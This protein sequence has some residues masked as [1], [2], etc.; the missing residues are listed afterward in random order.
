MTREVVTLALFPLRTVL[1]PGGLL[2]LRIFETRYVDMVRNCMREQVP[3]GVV[4]LLEGAEAGGLSCFATLGTS[5]RIAD[6][7]PLP[8]GLLGISC[9]GERKFRVLRHW[10][11]ADLLNMGEVEW[12][13]DEPSE[14]LPQRHALLRGLLEQAMAKVGQH[15][16]N[17]EQQLDDA[18]WIGYRLSE[19][20]SLPVEERQRSLELADPIERIDWLAPMLDTA[21]DPS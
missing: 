3:F 7:D 16:D 6:F 13:G 17:W 15:Y 11:A 12:L 19:L 4:L 21:A 2:P 20:M 9:R 18:S 8:D 10:R 14:S 1:F 5:A